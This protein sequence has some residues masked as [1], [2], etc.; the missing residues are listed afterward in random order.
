VGT[1]L[2]Y[3]AKLPRDR[4]AHCSAVRDVVNAHLPDGYEERMQRGMITWC[5]PLT[6]L[7]KT[8]DGRPLGLAALASR[9]RDSTLFLF[10]IFNDAKRR[11]W[12]EA[13]FARSGKPLRTGKLCVLFVTP[14]DLPL[15]VVGAAI[16][17]LSV[18]AYLKEYRRPRRP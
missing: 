8:H 10:A 18:T 12:F 17:K 7:A 15:D 9:A 11:A 1:V 2:D 3:L 13:A 6:T 4:R 5:V 14:D 16:G